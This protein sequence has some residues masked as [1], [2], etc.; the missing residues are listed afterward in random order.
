MITVEQVDTIN[1]AQVQR[2]IKIPYR[3]YANCPQWVPP[4]MMDVEAQLN[5]QKHPYYEHSHADFFIAVRNGQDVGR[6]AAL[7]NTRFNAYHGTHQAQFYLFEC[8]DDPEASK[9]LFERVFEW[10]H[11]KGLDHVVGPKGSWMLW[12]PGG[13]I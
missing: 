8:E 6:I 1:K 5:R 12:Y 4:L 10:S 2:F 9:A 11:A 7:E 3:L 13:G